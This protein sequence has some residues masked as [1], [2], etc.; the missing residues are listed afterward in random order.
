MLISDFSI[1]KPVVTIVAMLALVLFGA[2]ALARL[3]TDE[4]PDVTPPFVSVGIPYPGAGPETV[5]REVIDKLEE[6]FQS[7]TGVHSIRSSALDGYG[8]VTVRFEF[9]KDLQQAAQDVRDKISEKRDQ[10]PKEMREPVLR[11]WDPRQQPI[12]SLTLVSTALDVPEL[13]RLADPGVTAKLRAIP[14]VADVKVRGGVKRELV[15]EVEPRAL[16]AA[17]LSVDDVASALEAQNIAVPVGRVQDDFEERA[18]RLRGRMETPEEFA[19]LVVAN[20]GAQTIRLGSVARVRDGAE[21]LRNA[22][23]FNDQ[24]AVSIDIVKS[25]SASTTAVA[26]AVLREVDAVRLA[27]PAGTT[28]EVVRNT[29]TNVEQS[30]ADV[31]H[32]LI[33]GAILTVLVVFLFLNSWRSTVITGLALPVSVLASFIA[34]WA[35]G[36]TLNGMVLM[37]LSLAIG[38]LVDDAIVVRENI[39]RHI[40]LGKD[41]VTA[42]RDGTAEIGLAVAATT[43]AIIAVFVPIAFMGGEAQQWFEPFAL[44]IVCSVLVSLF[45]SFSLDPMLSAYWPEPHVTGARRGLGRLIA[46]F[47]A[48]IDGLTTHYQRLIAWSLAHR[49]T[50]IAIALV[51][52][53]GAIA[54]PMLRLV[55]SEFEPSVDWSGFSVHLETTPGSSIAYTREKALAAVAMARKNPEVRF[56]YTVIG[57]GDGEVDEAEIFVPLTRRDQRERSQNAIANSLRNDLAQLGGVTMSVDEG[58]EQKPIQ[59]R[60]TGPD[61][62]VL[63]SLADKVVS[64]MREV[65]NCIDVGLSVK[66]KRPELEVV[67]DRELAGAMGLTVEQVARAMR[68][69]FAGIDVGDWVDPAGRTRDVTVRL[70]PDARTRRADLAMLPLVVRDSSNRSAVVPLGQVARIVEDFGPSVI[71]HFNRQRVVTVTANTNGHALSEV[72]EPLEARLASIDVP[73]GYTIRQG[74]AAED[75]ADVFGRMQIA[76]AAAVVLMYLILVMQFG[77]FLEPLAIMASLPLSLIGVMLA[78][79]ATHASL[80][81][82]SIIGVVLLMGIVAKNAILLIDFAKSAEAMGLS[83]HKALIAAG[84]TRLR[85]ILMTSLAIIAGMLPVAIGAGE[86]SEYRAPLGCAVIGGVL[87][88][89]F[90]TLLVIPT[91]YDV[92]VGVRDRV[93]PRR[94]PPLTRSTTL[95]PRADN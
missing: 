81:L 16:A 26:S 72:L 32:T 30:V 65:P 88:S 86:G 51:A 83:R 54:M 93:M 4:Y 80:N 28:L 44:T 52:F 11:S 70:A 7:I 49:R 24:R 77:S 63:S 6:A 9:E 38:I 89:T 58:S 64:A 75:Q 76:L 46:R 61:S 45:V 85:P 25:K 91:F 73:Q 66:G 87:T 8:Y 42:A 12:V 43:F 57:D 78:L 55:P 3:N 74:G 48:R 62:R 14:G 92:L 95:E 18:I 17:G 39:V 82:M 69:A 29:G 79:Y 53:G 59:V 60:L 37:G 36:Y 10:L 5:E 19:T 2:L 84:E 68:P 27:L 71:R 56:T 50:V 1:K 35:M 20:R 40:E 31:E 47:N 90:L 21:E 41:H 67:V 33:E 13:T 23:F 15:V 22:A 34:V 94:A